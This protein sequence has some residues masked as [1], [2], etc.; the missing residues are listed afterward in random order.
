MTKIAVLGAKGRLSHCVAR[1]FHAAGHE[2]VAVSRDGRAE[3]LPADVEQ[4]AADALNRAEL[5]D[6]T[7]GADVI[8]NG[9]NPIYTEWREKV[10]PMARNVVAAARASG[11]V[12]ILAGNV[13]NYGH[14]I[15][16][17]ADEATPFSRST[18][19]GNLRIDMEALFQRAATEQGVQTIVL[20]A[21][22]FFGT[23]KRGSW[24]DLVVAGRLGKGVVTYPG[25]A[26]LP[27]AWA[28]LPDLAEAFVALAERRELFGRFETFN[29]AGHTMTGSE[30]AGHMEAA[31]GRNLK[32]AGFPWIA[33][34]AGG[35]FNPMWREIAEMSY[36]WFTPHR[37]SGRKLAAAV[38]ELAPTPA[39]QAVH[40]AIADL[41]LVDA[42]NDGQR[43]A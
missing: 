18:R 19:K 14:A 6:A 22:D 24:F 43:V 21:G 35:L 34:R 9:L 31:L 16:P 12:H 25:P 38:G 32:R 42:G 13:Y 7:A 33:V 11:A 39:H 5:I 4:R 37:L 40:R 3:G 27:H 20:R 10:M 15:P 1:A 29:F 26:D 2:V 36:L 41:G 8:F 30:L 23:D 17:L 28:Y